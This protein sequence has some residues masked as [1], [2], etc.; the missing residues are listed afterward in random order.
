MEKQILGEA[1]GIFAHY[2]PGSG[3]RSEN[4]AHLLLTKIPG[5]E[6]AFRARPLRGAVI[7]GVISAHSVEVRNRVQGA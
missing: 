3:I 7:Q 4:R 2:A 5:S 6:F 1:D